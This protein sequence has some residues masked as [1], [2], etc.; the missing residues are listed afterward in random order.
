MAKEALYK[1][2]ESV[3]YVKASEGRLGQFHKRVEEVH[4]DDTG[5]FLRLDVS[6]RWNATY[7]M[8]ES[9]INYHR[10]FNSLT[11]NYISDML[12]PAN[13]E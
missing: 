9:T 4:L 2:R 5:S 1:I 11:F 13:E 7:M 12:C 6:T 8:L 10:A 3:K